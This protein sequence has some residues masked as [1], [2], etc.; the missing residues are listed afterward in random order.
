MPVMAPADIMEV[1][2]TWCDEN[3]EEGGAA[4]FLAAMAA[5][6]YA[7]FNRRMV[8]FVKNQAYASRYEQAAIK[9]L[10]KATQAA[11]YQQMT[12]ADCP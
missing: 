11:D 12:R 6:K 1:I 7:A 5:K 4:Y 10:M 8:V 2:L 3:L 9:A